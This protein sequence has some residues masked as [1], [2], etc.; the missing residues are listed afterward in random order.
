MQ[1]E[2]LANGL[3]VP[4]VFFGTYRVT[5]DH[6]ME[7][8]L[9]EAYECGYRSFDSASFYKNEEA[10]GSAFYTMGVLDDVL[11]TTKV[12]NDVE[13]RDAVLRS[14]EQSEK[15]LKRVDIYLL[16]WPAREFIS[17]WKALEELYEAGRVKA[18]G[19]S[20][21]KKHHLEELAAHANIKPMVNQIEAHGY[22]MDEET[23]AYCLEQGIALQAWRPLM[24]TGHMLEN[25]DIAKIGERYGQTAA[26]VALRYLLQRGFTVI[27]KSVHVERMQENIDIFDFELTEDE[28]R[29]MR[30]LNTGV[31]TAGDPDTFILP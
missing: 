26:Q 7:S 30:S 15:K 28:M 16:H 2:R 3:C 1:Y 11:L 25:Q 4:K 18:I 23:I 14:F 6:S 24:R 17:R 27:P 9:E 20:N 19:V 8:V 12:W 29:F 22:F 21:F 5:D 13:G 10:V 31:R